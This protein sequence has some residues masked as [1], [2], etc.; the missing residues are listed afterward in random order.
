MRPRR[1]NDQ[2][3]YALTRLKCEYDGVCC[4]CSMERENSNITIRDD[5]NSDEL[6]E[7]LHRCEIDGFVGF[8]F[9]CFGHVL[10]RTGDDNRE[11]TPLLLLGGKAFLVR[12]RKRRSFTIRWPDEPIWYTI[13]AVSVTMNRNQ[14]R[15]LA[16]VT[17]TVVDLTGNK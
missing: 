4:V 17:I 3:S 11:K 1:V 12:K 9:F 13:V 14:W 5:R 15:T 7:E 16:Q 8:F 2:I 10:K 6:V